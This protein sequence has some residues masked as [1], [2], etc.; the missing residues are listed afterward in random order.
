MKRW[1]SRWQGPASSAQVSRSRACRPEV[2]VPLPAAPTSLAGYSP[3]RE[4]FRCSASAP[5]AALSRSGADLEVGVPLPARQFH[6]LGY[7]PRRETSRCSVSAPFAA[8]S[9]SGADLEVG[10]PLPA[11][12]SSLAG[13]S[14]RRETSRCSGFSLPP[15]FG[16][17]RRPEVGVPLPA[18]HAGGGRWEFRGLWPRGRSEDRRSWSSPLFLSPLEA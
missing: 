15:A 1:H 6:W 13:Y 3:R 5:F 7:S 9:R 17:L 10:V 2:G 18:H 8:L 16:G 11:A 12:P 4:T 14:P